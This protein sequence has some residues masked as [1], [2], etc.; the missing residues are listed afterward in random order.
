MIRITDTQSGKTIDARDGKD[1]ALIVGNALDRRW[2]EQH[3][4]APA[5]K[6]GEKVEAA[7]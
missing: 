6:A 1:A 5:D 7:A 4:E 2:Y 3:I